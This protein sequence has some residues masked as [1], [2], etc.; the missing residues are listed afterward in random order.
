MKI[1]QSYW[2]KPFYVKENDDWE[3]RKVGGW[4]TL[5]ILLF[6]FNFNAVY[7]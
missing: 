6:E 2:T 3:G 7:S 5:E 4:T 1:I